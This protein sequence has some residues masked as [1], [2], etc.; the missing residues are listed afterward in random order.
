VPHRRGVLMDF[1]LGLLHIIKAMADAPL[2]CGFGT[3]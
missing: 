1:S 3:H 2:L